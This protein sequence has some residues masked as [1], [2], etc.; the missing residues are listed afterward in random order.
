MWWWGSRKRIF[1]RNK[2]KR[3]ISQG[4]TANQSVFWRKRGG[5]KR[6][7][8][9]CKN[10]G[11]TH[12]HISYI[13]RGKRGRNETVLQS[14]LN[15]PSVYPQVL[16]WRSVCGERRDWGRTPLLVSVTYLQ[17]KQDCLMP[18]IAAPFGSVYQLDDTFINITNSN[19]SRNQLCTH[20]T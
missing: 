19:K 15:T 8:N 7:W 16:A 3:K 1:R 17:S 11:V 10:S 18:L 6:I 20:R 2:K 13:S 4:E 5:P 14:K 12:V 9:E